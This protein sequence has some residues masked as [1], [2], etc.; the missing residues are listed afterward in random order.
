[1]VTLNAKWGA[2]RG[3]VLRLLVAVALL[4]WAAARERADNPGR[5][6]S[7]R[8]PGWIRRLSKDRRAHHRWRAGV[9]PGGQATDTLIQI[10]NT[11]QTAPI[12]L[13]CWWVNANSHCGGCAIG[14]NLRP[15]LHKQRGLSAGLA[16]PARL[17]D[18]RLRRTAHG[19]AAD[20]VPS[21]DG[22]AAF[23]A[24]LRSALSDRLSRAG[25]RQHQAGTG[26]SLQGELKCVQTGQTPPPSTQRRSGGGEQHQG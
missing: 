23:S 18:G 12:D 6:R 20:R 24:A 5:F 3:S 17:D 22:A 11:S 4:G 10:S 13:N 25:R 1:M 26:E 16:L 9:L 8:P 2:G 7:V 15:D 19:R 21:L 14:G